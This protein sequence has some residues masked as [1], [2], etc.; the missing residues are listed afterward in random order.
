MISEKSSSLYNGFE[1]S[2][3]E[4]EEVKQ[5]VMIPIPLPMSDLTSSEWIKIPVE[6]AYR[7]HRGNYYNHNGGYSNSYNN[8][9]LI[10]RLMFFNVNWTLMEV[11]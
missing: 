2:K 4:S 1:E 10:T 9:E 6:S 3:S 8:K 11:F 5:E 7:A